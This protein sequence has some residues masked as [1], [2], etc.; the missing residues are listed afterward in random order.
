MPLPDDAHQFLIVK[1]LLTILLSL[2]TIHQARSS[3]VSEFHLTP[4]VS[5]MQK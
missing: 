5:V 4:C 1:G 3:N 2:T